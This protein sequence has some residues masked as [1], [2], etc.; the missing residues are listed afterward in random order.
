M[1]EVVITS[2]AE[3]DFIESLCWCA[4]R[5]VTAAND[6]DQK[7]QR[8]VSELEID[9]ERFPLYDDPYRFILMCRFPFRVI[10]RVDADDVIIMAVAHS[11]RSPDFWTRR[12]E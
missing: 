2:V 5:D 6:F 9:P 10:F 4:E 8:V 1:T 12:D 11:S 7:F 3:R